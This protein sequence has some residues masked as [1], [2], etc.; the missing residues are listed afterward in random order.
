MALLSEKYERKQGNTGVLNLNMCLCLCMT[1]ITLFNFGKRVQWLMGIHM[2]NRLP[3]PLFEKRNESI[4][5]QYVNNA[6][7]NANEITAASEQL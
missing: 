5:R 3:N 4:Q 1:A 7:A 2:M 6:S